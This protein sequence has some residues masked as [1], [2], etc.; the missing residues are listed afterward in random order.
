MRHRRIFP[1][2]VPVPFACPDMNDI[3][4]GN[5][6]LVLLGCNDPPPGRHDENLIAVVCVPTRCGAFAK[7]DDVAAEIIRFPVSNHRLARTAYRTTRPPGDWRRTAH[8]FFRQIVEL[9]HTHSRP[10]RKCTGA[11]LRLD[12][13]YC[14]KG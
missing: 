13:A 4:D 11:H 6:A 10:P 1:G 12:R 8:G 2:A 3:A 9:Y 14:T 5:F 7:I